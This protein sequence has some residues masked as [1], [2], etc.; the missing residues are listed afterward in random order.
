MPPEYASQPLRLRSDQIGPGYGILTPRPRRLV[1]A[2]HCA[3]IILDPVCTPTA[4]SGQAA[5]SPTAASTARTAPFFST[6]GACLACPA[7]TSY[8]TRNATRSAPDRWP[9]CC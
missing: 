6:L 5:A 9:P 4:L 3:G 8:M 1:D 2:A 7:T